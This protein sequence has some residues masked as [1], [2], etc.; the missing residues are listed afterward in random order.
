MVAPLEGYAAA[1]AAGLLFAVSDVLVRLGARTLQPLQLLLASL[2]FGTPL[3]F[4][5]AAASGEP[6]PSGRVLAYYVLAGL[7][8][9]VVGRLLFY[10]AVA[11]AG[12]ATASIATSPT[13]LF[14]ALLAWLILGEPLDPRVAV[15]LVLVFLGVLLASVEPSGRPLHGVGSRLAVAAGMAS[16]LVFASTSIIVRAAGVEGGSPAWGVAVSYAS[17]L[18]VVAAYSL[19]RL[20]A[21]RLLPLGDPGIRYAAGAAVAVAVAQL[22]RYVSLHLLPVA[23]AV[24]LISLFPVHTVVLASLVSGEARERVGARHLAGALTAFSGIAV[25]LGL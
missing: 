12:A 24:I 9:F 23:Y 6:L 21:R 22:S 14:S 19:R 13:V 11:G 10:Y 16:S 7:L 17:A 2:V 1:F 15:G 5:A 25:A 3:L 18:P 20:G 8:N 4:A